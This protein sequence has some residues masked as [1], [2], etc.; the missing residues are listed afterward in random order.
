MFA[1]CSP[2]VAAIVFCL[3][4]TEPFHVNTSSQVDASG[5]IRT[6]LAPTPRLD[7]VEA[8]ALPHRHYDH[9]SCTIAVVDV[10]GLLLNAD[11]TGFGSFGENPVSVFRERLDAI[12]H[13][14][15][16]HAV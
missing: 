3:G 7:P 13:D 14:P 2:F 15:R 11:A 8:A 5:D 12:E 9:N 1:R 6:E 4:C 16:V 10:D